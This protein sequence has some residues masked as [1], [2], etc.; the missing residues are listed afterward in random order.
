M[1]LKLLA[2]PQIGQYRVRCQCHLQAVAVPGEA[3]FFVELLGAVVLPEDVQKTSGVSRRAQTV[4]DLFHH[5]G[6]VPLSPKIRV[7]IERDQLPP[8]S[9]VRGTEIA[10]GV[11]GG[12][13]HPGGAEGG[14]AE[15]KVSVIQQKA[16]IA[17]FLV[18]LTKN[19]DPSLVGN[20]PGHVVGGD[21]VLVGGPPA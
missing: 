2:V 8:D 18:V 11:A 14:A 1:R 19:R 6:A 5:H 17:A 12:L 21:A 15:G 13:V 16:V 7:A 9:Q 3:M 4:E 10:D 20:L